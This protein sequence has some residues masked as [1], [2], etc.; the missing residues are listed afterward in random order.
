MTPSAPSREVLLENVGGAHAAILLAALVSITGERSRIDEFAP[1]FGYA[2]GA[3]GMTADLP[4]DKR[5]ELER[6]AV[7]VLSDEAS[8][9]GAPGPA[10]A[11][12]TFLT[13]CQALVG[14]PQ[15]P[16]S[17]AFLREQGGFASF[18]PTVPR[19]KA[20]PADFKVVIIGAGMAGINMAI[21][22]QR[23]GF[24]YVILEKKDGLGGVWWQNRYPGVGVDTPS[25]YYSFSFEVNPQ[26]TLSYPLGGEYLDYLQRVA[27]KYG[28]TDRFE[29]GADVEELVWD[30]SQ[31]VWHVGYRQHGER[32]EMTANAVVTAAGFLTNNQLPDVPGIETFGGDWWHS[33]EWRDD[34]DL[35]G[36]RV[37]VVGTGCTSVQVVDAIAPKVAHLTVF[38]RQPH[39]VTPSAGSAELPA[40]ERWL[41]LNVPT[42]ANWARLH[43]FLPIGDAGYDAVRW[44]E[45]WA[46]DH[47]MSISESNHVRL[48]VGLEYLERSFADRPDLK[49]KLTPSFAFMGKRPIRDPGSYYETLKRDTTDLVTS[50]LREVVPE[51]IVDDDGTLHEV[52]VIV[53]A[54]GFTLEY[55]S[56]W[57]IVGRDGQKLTDKWDGSPLAYNGALVPGFPNLFITS[58]PHSSAAHG[59]GH[60]FTVEAMVHYIVECLQTVVETGAHYLEVTDDAY[61]RWRAEVYEAMA[62]TVWARELRATTYY[63]NTK[64]EVILASPFRMEDYWNRLREPDLAAVVV[65]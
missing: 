6:W 48:Q 42:Y 17:L 14:W 50:G 28:I 3:Q 18:V 5:T 49:E 56:S 41:L 20:P 51:G 60:N 22:A 26:W 52:D 15:A 8:Y 21:A 65:K 39:W 44:D 40:T 2:F 30:E 7:E 64:G 38:Q 4:P 10:V 47:D 63:R 43:T 62:D 54:T 13:L 45:E 31:S 27:D 11:D 57:T 1:H 35:T 55:L 61:E 25:R 59:G 58:G 12:E 16:E 19:T 37:A 53:Y 36:K 29:F 46:K 23:A 32:A 9:V 24:G 34:V 33:A